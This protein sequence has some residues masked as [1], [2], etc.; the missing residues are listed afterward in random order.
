MHDRLHRLPMVGLF[1]RSSD[2][3]R[4]PEPAL[5][6]ALEAAIAARLV[7]L[8]GAYGRLGPSARSLDRA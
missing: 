3:V 1:Y 6:A 8:D 2:P 4:D 5:K 7:A